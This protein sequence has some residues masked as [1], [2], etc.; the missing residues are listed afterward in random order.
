MGTRGDRVQWAVGDALRRDINVAGPATCRY[1]DSE[2]TG[3]PILSPGRSAGDPQQDP[4]DQDSPHRRAA[5]HRLPSTAG[6]SA[7]YS[8]TSI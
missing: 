5:G 2:K 7:T 1:R 4:R 8:M 3:W 6:L